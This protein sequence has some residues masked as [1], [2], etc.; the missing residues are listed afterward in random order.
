[1]DTAKFVF[2]DETAAKTNMTRLYGRSLFGERLVASAPHGHWKTTTF[3]AGLSIEGIVAPAVFDGPINAETFL[4]YVEQVVVPCLR[5][6]QTA[7]MDNLA[8]HKTPAVEAAV[9]AAGASILFTP[10]YSPDFNPIEKFFSKLKAH[11][12]KVCARTKSAL[13]DA[14]ANCCAALTPTECENFFKSCGYGID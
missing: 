1:M 10:A 8:A 12:R 6:G 4:A 5:P 11:L 7:V 3:V 9:R 14:I 2:F 13:D